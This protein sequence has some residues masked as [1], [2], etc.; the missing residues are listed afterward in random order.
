MSSSQN[1]PTPEQWASRIGVILAVAGSAVGFGNFLRFP[2]LA[3]Q[4]GGGAFMVAYFVS[5]LL[6]GFPVCVVEWAL[7][8]Y[9][10]SKGGHTIPFLIWRMTKSPAFKY[11]SVLAVIS[12]LLIGAYYLCL[13]AWTFFYAWQYFTG[14]ISGQS[15]EFFSSLFARISGIQADGSVFNWQNG[16]VFVFLLTALFINFFLIF[17]GIRKGIELF[18]KWA[19]P[20][21]IIISLLMIVRVLTLG[22]PDPAY[23]ERSVEAGLTYMWEP[24][25]VIVEKNTPSGWEASGIVSLYDKEKLAAAESLAQSAP[26]EYK[27]TRVS[28]MQE[29][30]KPDVWLAAAGQMFFSLSVGFCMVFTYASYLR[31]RDDIALSSLSAFSAN[32]FCEVSIGG[33]M[34]VPAAVTFLG[35]AGAAG[36][37]TFALGF[38]VLPQV[39]T[40]MPGGHF[41]GVLFFSLLA[42]A[43]VTSSISMLQPGIAF[44][45]E[46]GKYSRRR[47]VA[48]LF[49]III[50]GAFIVSWFSHNLLAL[51][52]LDFFSATLAP[53]VFA[54]VLLYLFI[55][56]WGVNHGFKEIDKG[57][58]IRIPRF[59]KFIIQYITPG[60]LLI[61]FFSS[62]IDNL[63]GSRSAAIQSLVEGKLAAWVAIAWMTLVIL[64][65]MNVLRTSPLCKK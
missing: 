56:K 44:L 22:T 11:F 59:F 29:L 2:G 31:R 10:G 1:S 34:T 19:M 23:P 5:L 46:F 28:M 30:S 13:E 37:S 63:W 24:S 33:L 49:L 36:Q 25:K 52:V 62:L 47:S 16:S 51:E 35:I 4:Y 17:Q 60:I 3:A 40:K 21:L 41:F 45:E 42:I 53:I 58:A 26:L 15:P 50:S 54:L 57:A 6:L 64:F 38:N 39:F 43:A 7:G 20:A 12:T 61:I 48:T 9:S 65:M 55:F 8:R 27:L 32:E 14:N 18:C